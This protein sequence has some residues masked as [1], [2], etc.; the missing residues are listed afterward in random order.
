VLS[1]TDIVD[2]DVSGVPRVGV[3]NCEDDQGGDERAE[4]SVEDTIERV[5]ERVCGNGKLVPVPGR[6]GVETKT[7]KTASNCGQVDVVRG[8][9]GHPV[10]VGHGPDDVAGE[11]GVD[12]HGAKTVHE[13][14]HPRDR[15]AV[16]DS[17]GLGVESSLRVRGRNSSRTPMSAPTYVQCDSGQVGWPNGTRWVYKESAGKASE[18]ISNK[19]G[20]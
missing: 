13:P 2:G 19:I 15:P 3:P 7:A 11:P 18:T 10:E 8:N 4:E 14:P 16:N 17:V 1:Q 5:D 20:R 12:E 6:E 9:P